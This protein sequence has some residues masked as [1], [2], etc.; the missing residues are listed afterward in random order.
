[1]IAGGEFDP[2]GIPN[3][4]SEIFD[5]ED[6]GREL[7][8]NWFKHKI[9]CI[10][11]AWICEETKTSKKGRKKEKEERSQSVSS[12]SKKSQRKKKQSQ[13]TN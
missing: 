7:T 4:D 13:R 3:I 2:F 11:I 12:G 5:Y 8:F 9:M 1:M 10:D 6:P